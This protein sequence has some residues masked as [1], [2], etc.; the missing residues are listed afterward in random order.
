MP[1]L[2][3]RQ[4]ERSGSQVRKGL[5]IETN[6]KKFLRAIAKPKSQLRLWMRES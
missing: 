5:W 1:Y 4:A 6:L 3:N 2:C